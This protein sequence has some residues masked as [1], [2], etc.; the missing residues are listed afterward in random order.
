VLPRRRVPSA[1]LALRLPSLARLIDASS[2]L[3]ISGCLEGIRCGRSPLD[4]GRY[5]VRYTRAAFASRGI[6]TRPSDHHSCRAHFPLMLSA[7]CG[8]EQDSNLYLSAIWVR[9]FEP[10][11]ARTPCGHVDQATPYPVGGEISGLVNPAYR[12]LTSAV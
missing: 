10:L 12:H 5:A 9:G 6:R 8:P 4:S 11:L 2:Q 3:D 7:P 1:L